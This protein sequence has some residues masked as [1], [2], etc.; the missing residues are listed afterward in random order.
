MCIHCRGYFRKRNTSGI[1]GGVPLLWN[2]GREWS[3]CIILKAAATRQGSANTFKA[4]LWLKRLL[5][6]LPCNPIQIVDGIDHILAG[7]IAVN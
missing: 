4:L 2:D 3:Q 7:C 1:A 6:D 5:K